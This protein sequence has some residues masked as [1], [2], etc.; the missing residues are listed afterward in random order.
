MSGVAAFVESF[1]SRSAGV[2]FLDRLDDIRGRMIWSL[3]AVA[4]GTGIGFYLSVTYDVL[5]VLTAPIQPYLGGERLKYLSPT[6]P[7][8][9]TL[10]LA[11]CI[12]L[13]LALPYLLVQG[14][15][16]VAPLMRPEERRLLAPA[17]VAGV[18]LF[19]IG[20]VFCYVL[21]VPLMLQFTMGFQADSL[22]QSIVV[23]EYL[24]IVL[25]LMAAFGL[26]FELPIVILLG[27]VLGV[28]TPEFLTL[29]RRHAI[30]IITI[31]SALVTPPDV[32]SLILLAVP[33]CLLYEVSIIL[34][35]AIVA[36]R[37]PLAAPEA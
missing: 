35:R 21:V 36:R 6:D 15:K 33:V 18:V 25:R 11:V 19:V 12:G 29:W 20:V 13:L 22:E 16:V 34:S 1:R 37:Q 9:I 24:K 28:V 27:T 30:A 32:A 23:G 2:S 10:K 31:S 8:F 5:G 4:V 7:F 17:V 14:W 3:V 26:A